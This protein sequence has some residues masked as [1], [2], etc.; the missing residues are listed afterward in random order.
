[1]AGKSK[2]KT[3]AA[4]VV[5]P[6]ADDF[7]ELKAVGVRCG[8]DVRAMQQ[9]VTRLQGRPPSAEGRL[10]LDDAELLSLIDDKLARAF[11]NLDDFSLGQ[12]S[13]RDLSVTIGVLT[14][15]RRLLRPENDTPVQ[16]FRDMRKLDEVLEEMAKE[17]KRRGLLY[18]VTP[19]AAA[20]VANGGNK[21]VP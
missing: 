15:K 6:S 1:M 20:P 13:A 4:L 8:I 19:P 7:E 5:Q 16:R 3:N 2:S 11:Q 10:K 14:D 17:M 12:S 21:G 9:L 18:E